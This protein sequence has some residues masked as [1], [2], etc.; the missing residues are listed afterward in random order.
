MTTPHYRYS[1]RLLIPL[2][3]VLFG[4]RSSLSDDATLLLSGAHPSPRV[5]TPENI[6]ADSPFILVINH[7]DRPGLGAWWSAAV[8]A[9]T[10]AARRMRAPHEL[11]LAMA[12]EWW[13]PRGFGKWVK[14]PFTRW[15]QVLMSQ[16][17]FGLTFFLARSSRRATE[18]AID[19]AG[20]A[21]A[22][23][24]TREALLE[25]AFRPGH[26]DTVH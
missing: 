2:V 13:Y 4:I 12:R 7:Y 25:E 20:Q 19:Q 16:V 14:Q 5:L 22:Q 8:L 24:R 6:P 18:A 9:T 11:R 10:I 3:R 21:Q 26:A 15:F 1:L 17:I 23:V